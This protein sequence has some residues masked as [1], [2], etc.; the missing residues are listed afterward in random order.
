MFIELLKF[1]LYSLIAIPFLYMII[2][3]VFDI[4]KRIYHHFTLKNKPVPVRIK[5][6]DADHK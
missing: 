5:A 3:V 4:S 6:S 2:E 1:L